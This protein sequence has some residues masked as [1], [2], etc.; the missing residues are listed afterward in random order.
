MR[1]N[2]LSILAKFVGASSAQTLR[3]SRVRTSF[4]AS[5]SIT[6]VADGVQEATSRSHRG[7]ARHFLAV[8]GRG[9]SCRF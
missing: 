6:S 5:E 4:Q 7:T 8:S 1:E 2:L 3:I 9:P